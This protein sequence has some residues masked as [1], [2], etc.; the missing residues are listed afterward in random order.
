MFLIF[1]EGRGTKEI[2][3]N[4][5]QTLGFNKN[6]LGCEGKELKSCSHFLVSPDHQQLET[7]A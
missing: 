5:G 3:A 7:F 1:S 2:D 4:W 6:P